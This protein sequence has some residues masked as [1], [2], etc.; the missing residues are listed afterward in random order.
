MTRLR[1]GI[2]I[3]VLGVCAIA[4]YYFAL[5]EHVF[6]AT[7]TRGDIYVAIALIAITLLSLLTSL[8]G[9]VVSR[10]RTRK[11]AVAKT[12]LLLGLGA[13]GARRAIHRW[14]SWP[15]AMAMDCRARCPME[16]Q[17]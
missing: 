14:R 1:I 17:C 5:R 15:P 2:A 6:H 16:H 4:I 11:Y 3:W 13:C 7:S 10:F 8:F 9:A 12:A